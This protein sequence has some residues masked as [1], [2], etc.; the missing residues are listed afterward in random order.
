MPIESVMPSS[1]LI[2]CHYLL[3]LPPIP[4]S[5]RVFSNESTLRMRWPNIGVSA[6]A[7]VLPMNAQD[8][9]PFRWTDWISLQSKGRS[10]VFS[11]ITVQKDQFFGTQLS[12]QTQD[13]NI[14]IH[15]NFQAAN[16]PCRFPTSRPHNHKTK[17]N[18]QFLRRN[19]IPST[20][21]H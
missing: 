7:S 4:P 20:Y 6:S 8:S 16:R 15:L 2:L 21:T 18:S 3:L 14:N 19:Q 13:C 1:H 11:N 10:R 17:V 9:S 5:I 12:S